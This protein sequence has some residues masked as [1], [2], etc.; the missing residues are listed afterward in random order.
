MMTRLL[1]KIIKDKIVFKKAI[2]VLGSRQTGKTTLLSHITVE[3]KNVL[4]LN[5]DNPIVRQQLENANYETLLQ[6]IGSNKVLFIDEAQRVKNIGLTLKIIIDQ[7]K[8]VQLFISGS[9]AF[10]LANEMNEPLTGR[11]WEYILY[12]ISWQEF[13]SNVGYLTAIQQFENRLIY[14][15]YPEIINK[16]GDEI[17]VLQQL[18][19]SLLYKDILSHS[20]IRK[21][22]VLEKLLRALALQIGSEVNFNELS[23]LLRVD[24]NTVN[25]YINLLEKTF[26]IFRLNPLSRNLRNEI[27]TSRKI[28]FYDNGIRNSLISNFSPLEFREDKG[29]LFENFLISERVKALHYNKVY[30]NIYFWRTT[31]QQEIDYVEDRNGEL[32]AFE[33]K[34]SAGKNPKLP[35]TFSKNYPETEFKVINKEN[36]QEFLNIKNII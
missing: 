16:K 33:F 12:P 21:P 18:T 27:N 15:M 29:A 10:E 13:E 20:G 7:I 6:L 17:E 9:S 23:S 14:G 11:K 34:F 4:F 30:S 2:I 19:T 32:F 28:Y 26:I 22:D 31:Q 3:M 1:E 25:T 35:I 5:C 24:K 36:F 8:D